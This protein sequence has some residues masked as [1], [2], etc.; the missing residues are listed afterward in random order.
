MKLFFS[1]VILLAGITAQAAIP[2]DF[3]SGKWT[4]LLN[5][6]VAQ[7]QGMQTQYGDFKTLTRI[8]PNN[9]Q[10]A[11]TAD[12]F[13][14]VGGT[15]TDGVFHAG[16]VEVVSENWQID[17]N[18][19]WDIHQWQYVVSMNGDVTQ[20]AQV[21]LVEKQNREVV[22]DDYIPTTDAQALTNLSLLLK[23]WYQ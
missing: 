16:H 14:L 23:Q 13:S 3:D 20:Y 5:R 10:A 1:L 21:H 19:N 9:E 4:I 15:D 11:H 17:Q 22:S 18:G 12:Y 8:A 7:G 6:T 2:S